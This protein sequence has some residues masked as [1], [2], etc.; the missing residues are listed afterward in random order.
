MSNTFKITIKHKIDPKN[1]F[2]TSEDLEIVILHKVFATKRSEA[3]A[4][5]KIV[6]GHIGFIANRPPEGAHKLFAVLSKSL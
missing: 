3:I 2:L 1:G 6:G 4:R 5:P